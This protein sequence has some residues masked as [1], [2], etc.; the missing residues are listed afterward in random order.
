MAI[1]QKSETIN[2]AT[3]TTAIYTTGNHTTIEKAGHSSYNQ[4]GNYTTVEEAFKQ[5]GNKAC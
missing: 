1:C 4:T 2:R 5:T 3:G